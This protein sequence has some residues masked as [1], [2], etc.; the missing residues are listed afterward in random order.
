MSR[1]GL[2]PT[3]WRS[4]LTKFRCGVAPLRIET[5]RYEGSP[6]DQRLRFYCK[7]T[8][9]SEHVLLECPLYKDI[10]DELYN[11]VTTVYNNFHLLDVIMPE[12]IQWLKNKL[13]PFYFSIVVA[14]LSCP[15]IK[16]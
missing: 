4:A 14:T 5:G 15:N 10:S 9:E 8:I 1:P 16:P 13:L 11:N 12:S 3:R 6:I 7:T 2:E